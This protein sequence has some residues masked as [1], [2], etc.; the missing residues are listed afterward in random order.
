M[1]Q[2][3]HDVSEHPCFFCFFRGSAVIWHFLAL[4]LTAYETKP[5][6]KWKE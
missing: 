6:R 2:Q 4:A 5:V 1:T 3:G